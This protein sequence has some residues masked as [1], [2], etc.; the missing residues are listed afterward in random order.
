MTG[1]K[2]LGHSLP[3]LKSLTLIEDNNFLG[4]IDYSQIKTHFPELTSLN[5]TGSFIRDHDLVHLGHLKSLDL[6][7]CYFITSAGL[8]YLTGLSRVKLVGCNGIRDK[9]AIEELWKTVK[10]V[11]F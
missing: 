2:D 7:C 1:L 5:V 9:L 10:D 4:D 6:S 3:A 8:T 11:E